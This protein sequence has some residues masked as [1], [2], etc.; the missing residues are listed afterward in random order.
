MVIRPC[1]LWACGNIR[2]H[3]ECMHGRKRGLPHDSQD[4]IRERERGWG[5]MMIPVN[6]TSM[7]CHQ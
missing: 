7:A 2:H 3:G 1:C 6:R 5:P 4:K